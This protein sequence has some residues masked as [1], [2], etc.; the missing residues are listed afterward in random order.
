MSGVDVGPPRSGRA[1]L[2]AIHYR[3]GSGVA[4]VVLEL[5]MTYE[6]RCSSAPATSSGVERCAVSLTSHRVRYV[7]QTSAE[8]LPSL[9]PRRTMRAPS[10]DRII[11]RSLFTLFLE[12]EDP[13]INFI[14]K[15]TASS[16]SR[17]MTGASCGA[18]ATPV[19]LDRDG[20][21]DA[22][23][24]L[25]TPQHTF[26]FSLPILPTCSVLFTPPSFF[27]LFHVFLS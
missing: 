24:T 18:P 4:T 5:S 8:E 26:I 20:I 23:P 21:A 27:L 3:E 13:P 25:N 15:L 17:T 7:A 2:R 11:S 22:P 16:V 19:Y 14:A 10:F 12:C 6:R 1:R 9:I